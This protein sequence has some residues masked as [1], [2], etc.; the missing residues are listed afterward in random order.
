MENLQSYKQTKWSANS[1]WSLLPQVRHLCSLTWNMAYFPR[2][3]IPVQQPKHCHANSHLIKISFKCERSIFTHKTSDP[4]S[5]ITKKK[6]Q[7]KKKDPLP[8]PS[9]FWRSEY[10]NINKHNSLGVL[11]EKSCIWAQGISFREENNCFF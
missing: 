10:L 7:K 8:P 11:K 3:Y 4:P 1:S 6:F 5:P 9:I 2:S